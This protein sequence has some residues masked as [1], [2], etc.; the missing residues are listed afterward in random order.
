LTVFSIFTAFLI[1]GVLKTFDKAL[2][3]GVELADA[4]RLITMSKISLIQP[5]PYAHYNKIKATE[6]VQNATFAVWYG[7]YYQDPKNFIGALAVESETY[8]DIYPEMVVSEEQRKNY[9]GNRRGLIV[10]KALAEQYGWQLGDT[11]PIMSNIWTNTDGS[12]AWEFKIEGIFTGSDESIDTRSL[13]FHYAYLNEAR[14]F[15]KDTI[16]WL[17]VKTTSPYLNKTVSEAI[18][19]QFAN[20]PNETKT[21]T[22]A[23]FGKAFL[24]Q[25]GN[26]GLIITSV[27]GAAFFTILLIAGNTMILAVRERTNEIAV[28]KT[29]GFSN[30]QVGSLIISE[31]MFLVLLGGLP[32]LGFSWIAIEVLKTL[33]G[34]NLPPMTLNLEI[35]LQATGY[36]LLLGLVTGGLPAFNALRIHVAAALGRKA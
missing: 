20:S 26:I 36:M 6:G 4:N 12:R 9:L 32:A 1:F 24:E 15:W 17:T 23:A 14:T 29:L 21:S 27:V 16:G 28:M 7:G 10:G 8:M 13:I 25:F 19:N 5:L 30:T 11:I 22:E 3:A 2:N 34:G 33:G 18:D 31:A 35:L